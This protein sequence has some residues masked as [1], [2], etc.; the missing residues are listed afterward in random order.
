MRRLSLPEK[1]ELMLEGTIRVIQAI[2]AFAS[3]DGRPLGRFLDMQQYNSSEAPDARYAF[4]F[5]LCGKAF[6]RVLVNSLQETLLDLADLYGYPWDDYK[7]AG[8]QSIW[9]SHPNWSR[10]TG[11]ELKQLESEVTDD[12][13][14]DYSEDELNFWFEG[15][16]DASYLFVSLQDIDE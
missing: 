13:R 5:D 3:L 4:T 10:L 9:I 15:S 11:R 2:L 12:L 7:V 14:F 1:P 16:P 8:Y 6:A